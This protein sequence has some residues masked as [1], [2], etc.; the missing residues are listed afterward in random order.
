MNKI[1]KKITFFF[2]FCVNNKVLFVLIIKISP[3]YSIFE[4]FDNDD[5][6]SLLSRRSRWNIG[7]IVE[8]MFDVSVDFVVVVFER[9]ERVIFSMIRIKNT[10]NKNLKVLNFY[11]NKTIYL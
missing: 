2:I 9:E 5:I 8:F 10:K 6:L 3:E 4:I 11:K 1:Y 7:G